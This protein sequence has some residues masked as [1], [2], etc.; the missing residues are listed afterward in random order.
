M[1]QFV[2]EAEG[3]HWVDFKRIALR[4]GD[5]LSVRPDQ[6][7]AF[8]TEA[9]HESLLLL[10][11]PDA[12]RYLGVPVPTRLGADSVLRP[13]PADFR[14]LVDLLR[15]LERIETTHLRPESVG[16]RLLGTLLA[17]LTDVVAASHGPTDRAAL[18]YEA[19]VRTFEAHLDAHHAVSRSPTWYAASMGTTPRTLARACR[20]ARGRSPKQMVDA[21][22]T[23]EAKRL[24]ATTDDTAEAIGYA[25]GFTE[26][27]NFV[28]FF[29]RVTGTTP[30]AFRRA[31]A[32]R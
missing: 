23:L 5:V 17:G 11:T 4:P 31:Q 20:R 27:T 13:A 29:R 32:T 8:D 14:F 21:R 6:V 10:F 22:V 12:P 28:K 16:T 24:L 2:T 30:D 25:L 1:L 3:A 15:L 26:A 9:A 7:H 19:L 18:R